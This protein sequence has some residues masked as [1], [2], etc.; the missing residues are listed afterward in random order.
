VLTITVRAVNQPPAFLLDPFTA[1]PVDVATPLTGSLA[2]SATD[3][4]AGDSLV[5]AKVNGPAWLTSQRGVLC[6]FPNSAVL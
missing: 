1:G 3:P 2:G 5:Y 4:D 6:H